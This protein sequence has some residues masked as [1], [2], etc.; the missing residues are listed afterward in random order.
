[1]TINP[2]KLDTF[3]EV[4]SAELVRA[5]QTHPDLYA[6]PISEVPAVL[7]RMREAIKTG[8]FN[9]DGHAFKATCKSLGIKQT[10]RDIETFLGSL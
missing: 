8:S 1:M 5:V 4:Y 6:Y 10:Y 2:Q 3:M 7:I 9:K